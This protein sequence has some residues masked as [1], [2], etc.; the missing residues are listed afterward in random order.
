M[1]A[2]EVPS[3]EAGHRGRAGLHRAAGRTDSWPALAMGRTIATLVGLLLLLGSGCKPEHAFVWANDLPPAE[4]D[5]SRVP[6]RTGDV[7][8][9]NVPG[10]EEELAKTGSM[11]VTADG[12][13]VVPILGP[14]AVEGLTPVQVAERLNARLK[15]IVQSPDATVSVVSPR[16]PVV[17]V[18][19]EVNNPG[20]WQIGTEEGVLQALARAGGLTEFAKTDEIFVVRKYPQLQRVR[21]RYDDL[22][23]GMERSINFELQD[24]DVI[25]VQ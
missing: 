12:M 18:V 7:I 3:T 5:L 10:L 6:L 17:A 8:L 11:T 15:G 13:V 1:P 24:G 25:V 2:Q 14:M 4:V 16:E 20:R 21:F 9:L 23:G 19:G 22:V